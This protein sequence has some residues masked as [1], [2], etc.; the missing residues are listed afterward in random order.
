M[1]AKAMI[2]NNRRSD[3]HPDSQQAFQEKAREYETM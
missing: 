2:Q 3:L 1:N